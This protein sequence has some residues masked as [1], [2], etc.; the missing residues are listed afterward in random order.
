MGFI[1]PNENSLTKEAFLAYFETFDEV[2]CPSDVQ[3]WVDRF[4]VSDLR[5]RRPS[6]FMMTQMEQ[7]RGK[8]YPLL[9][10][11]FIG[12]TAMSRT[13]FHELGHLVYSRL[14]KELVSRLVLAAREH[15]PV[16]SSE[17]VPVA[18]DTSTMKP[19]AVLKGS[20]LKI[21]GMLCGLD[22]SGPGA[23]G[24]NDELWAIL[25]AEYCEGSELPLKIRAIVEEIITALS[26][27]QE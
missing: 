18:I 7:G 20:Y 15:F 26:P 25:F 22:H 13:W 14:E 8:A 9:T 17:R 10:T 2:R 23:D 19:T 16:V 27:R 6:K 21:N 11:V 3:K 5:W 1:L 4:H 24:E 12:E